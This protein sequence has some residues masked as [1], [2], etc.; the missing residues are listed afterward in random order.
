MLDIGLAPVVGATVVAKKAWAS[1]PER[2]RTKMIE[3]ADRVEKHLEAEVPKQDAVAVALM[4][5]QGL[6]V[7]KAAGPEWRQE[8]DALAKAMRGQMVPAD[9]FDMAIDQR[10]AFRRRKPAAQ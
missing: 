9:V 6:K 7:T 10:D 5:L 3:S 8:A 4:S 2:D 1:V